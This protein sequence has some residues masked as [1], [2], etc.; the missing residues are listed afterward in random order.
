M[1][2]KYILLFL[3]FLIT[4]CNTKAEVNA[5]SLN[6][7][8][9]IVG[10]RSNNFPLFIKKKLNINISKF[11]E[12]SKGR[13]YTLK[14]DDREVIFLTYSTDEPIIL[15]FHERIGDIFQFRS[16]NGSAFITI[17]KRNGSEDLEL[18]ASQKDALKKQDLITSGFLH[19]SVTYENCLE[20]NRMNQLM[21]EYKRELEYGSEPD[22]TFYKVGPGYHTINKDSVL[23]RDF[24]STQGK[25]IQKLKKGETVA[26]ID[27]ETDYVEIEPYG[28]NYWIKI[29]LSNRKRGYIFGA[30]VQWKEDFPPGYKIED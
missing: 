13:E 20:R 8:C 17:Q 2:I 24:P 23:M 28:K 29:E 21:E 30:F 26:V 22:G 16:R 14:I 7:N 3:V 25:I 12:D 27:V 1:L 4:N 5:Q 11:E 6:P 9:F 15:Q 19:K 10:N 18:Y